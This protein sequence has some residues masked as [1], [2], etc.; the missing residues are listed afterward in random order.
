MPHI[1][2]RVNAKLLRKIEIFCDKNKISKTQFFLDSMQEKLLGDILSIE[3]D[4]KSNAASMLGIT[5]GQLTYAVNN[6]DTV[7]EAFSRLNDK[8]DIMDL[9]PLMSDDE[10][11]VQV[12]T[13]DKRT[14]IV[15]CKKDGSKLNMIMHLLEQINSNLLEGVDG[16]EDL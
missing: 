15:K 2:A 1:G 5:I 3:N 10:I 14:F 9:Y 11:G 16:W 8:S 13:N 4:W 12:T 6:A 7:T